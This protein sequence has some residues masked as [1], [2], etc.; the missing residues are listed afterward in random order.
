[1]D[2]TPA[3]T[4]ETEESGLAGQLLIAM[5]NIG[6]PRF[7]RTVIYVFNHQTTGAMGLIVNRVSDELKFGELLEQMKLEISADLEDTPV[8]FGGP[9]EL[10][11]GFVLHSP[12][13]HQ[14]DATMQIDDE[15]SVTTTVDVLHAIAAGRGPERML[16]A[17]GYS[18]WGPGQLEKE[19]RQNGWLQCEADPDIVFDAQDDTKW[20][21]ALAQIGVDPSLLSS[22]GGSA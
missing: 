10:E 14:D 6:D 22:A 3:D 18:G 7:D 19:I 13:Y 1:M 21:R 11:R 9:V 16:F 5:P 20:A 15:V 2:E 12:D 4:D 17:L 8:R